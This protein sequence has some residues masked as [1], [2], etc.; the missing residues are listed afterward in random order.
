LKH[1][2][3]E[4]W[5][6]GHHQGTTNPPTRVPQSPLEDHL[7][8]RKRVTTQLWRWKREFGTLCLQWSSWEWAIVRFLYFEDCFERKI[9]V[10]FSH[11]EILYIFNYLNHRLIP[12]LFA[13]S[14]IKSV[15]VR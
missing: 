6:P 7:Y 13:L 8:S 11:R 9:N 10:E 12:S 4:K 14:N 5:I 15:W 2:M 1:F 3:F